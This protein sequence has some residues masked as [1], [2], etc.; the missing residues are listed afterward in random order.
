MPWLINMHQFYG[1]INVDQ[2]KLNLAGHFREK[3]NLNNPKAVDFFVQE[4]YKVLHDAEHKYSD[5]HH[6]NRYIQP[7]V[8]QVY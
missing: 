8:N 5:W 3:S 6:F 4:G 7:S 1:R 2:A